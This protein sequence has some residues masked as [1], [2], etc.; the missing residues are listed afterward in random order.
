VPAIHPGVP[1]LAHYKLDVVPGS[2]GADLSPPA[3]TIE[4]HGLFATQTIKAG[5]RI[6]WEAPLITLPAPGDQVTDMMDAFESLEAWEQ[7]MIWS[8]NPAD[9]SASQLLTYMAEQITSKLALIKEIADMPE[10]ERTQEEQDI[11]CNVFPK[12]AKASEWFRIAARWHLA[13]YSLIDLPELERNNLPKGTP[14]TGLFIETARLRHSCVP[15][16]YAKYNPTTNLMTVHTMKDIKKAEELT[17]NTISSVY[18]HT[19]SQRAAELKAKFGTTCDCEACNPSHHK[20]NKHE[21]SRLA[22]HTRAI[23]LERFCTQLEIIERESVHTDLCLPDS[24]IPAPDDAPD[25]EDL[26]QAE[27]T[28]L[29]L[30]KN[31]KDTGCEGPELIRWYNALIDRVMPRVADA[32]ES[33]EERIRWWRIILRHAVEC[34]KLGLKC[35]GA[36]SGELGKAR[37]R[38]KGIEKLIGMAK[39]RKMALLESMRKVAIMGK[40]KD[41][42][43]KAEG[44]GKG[45]VKRKEEWEIV[46]RTEGIME[47]QE[48]RD[49]DGELVATL[50]KYRLVKK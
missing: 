30:I 9:S 42:E 6:I 40:I 38:T 43:M 26:N 16:C 37:M 35:F 49:K 31:L 15:N 12:I 10:D 44:M 4:K 24:Q 3:T 23:D 19:A 36:D 27:K 1:V 8:L 21:T 28:V 45:K 33:D 34:E 32:L 48:I 11:L 46:G 20:F 7:E 22:I 41:L 29:G 39:E 50:G 17:T 14:I 5:T 2:S 18:Y 47:E 25:I 13:R